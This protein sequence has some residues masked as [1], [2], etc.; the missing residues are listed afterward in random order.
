MGWGRDGDNATYRDILL[1][2]RQTTNPTLPANAL[3]WLNGCHLNCQRVTVWS[4]D[5]WDGE[6]AN[7]AGKTLERIS[8]TNDSTSLIQSVT[9][10]GGRDYKSQLISP[11]PKERKKTQK[12]QKKTRGLLW[13]RGMLRMLRCAKACFFKSHP[14]LAG[15]IPAGQCIVLYSS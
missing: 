12:K 6:S 2:S 8:G 9:Q 14:F 1:G 7:Q 11:P 10:P 13:Q 4:C 15:A 5:I 3:A